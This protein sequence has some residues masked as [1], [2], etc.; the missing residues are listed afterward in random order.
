[1]KVQNSVWLPLLAVSGLL[2]G[3]GG[4]GGDERPIV[5]PPPPPSATDPQPEPDPE[6]I[7]D[8][9]KSHTFNAMVASGRHGF[10][11]GTFSLTEEG[12]ASSG[13][14]SITFH[15]KTNSYT[16]ITAGYEPTFTPGETLN[17]WQSDYADYDYYVDYRKSHQHGWDQLILFKTSMD[18]KKQTQHVA[19]GHWREMF[20]NPS[21]REEGTFHTFVYGYESPAS[22]VPRTGSGSFQIDVFGMAASPGNE[23]R[24]FDGIGRFD[25][26]FGAGSFSTHAKLIERQYPTGFLY[27][28][29]GYELSGSG[30]LSGSDGTFSGQI[31]YGGLAGTLP[32]T[33]N[34]RFYGPDAS[35]LGAILSADDGKG[36]T[37]TGGIIGWRSS[38]LPGVNETLT[39]I[40]TPELFSVH[41]IHTYAL[42][43][44]F[45]GIKPGGYSWSDGKFAV[46]PD[47]TV[48]I[49]M[50]GFG[51]R[52]ETLRPS[53]RVVSA[54]PNFTVYEK[55]VRY[56][57]EPLQDE[58][59]RLELYKPG[60]ANTELQL[61]YASFGHWQSART[62]SYLAN[63]NRLYFAY[64]FKT[65][66][67]ALS[68]RT[69]SA[70]YRGVVY[71]NG[72]NADAR[73][74]YDVTGT[75]EFSVNFSHQTYFGNLRV[76]GKTSDS[77]PSVDFGSYRFS[78]ALNTSNKIATPLARSD[79]SASSSSGFLEADFYGPKGE[80]IGG[81][82]RLGVA[83][84]E[85]GGGTQIIGA[86]VARQQ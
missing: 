28:G 84:G 21:N 69:G 57:V 32:G 34:G 86:T 63:G 19:L 35:E 33:L 11:A 39:N 45:P 62:D 16:L 18:G 50:F 72:Y 66:E 41:G 17:W 55:T 3:C 13:K 64:G 37:V 46:R 53:S 71:G 31:T 9:T 36:Y 85:P 2:A 24:T 22:A 49:M 5:T 60:Q 67:G 48:E 68:A 80:E 77:A 47:G 15:A 20:T 44:E 14:F 79:I 6:P 56:P 51:L 61:T 27:G 38:D 4:G 70:Y 40:R 75:S 1:M 59:I 82:F 29:P 43:T 26:D 23:P 81:A 12:Q 65:P 76:S 74:R 42:N 8:L 52:T 7:H 73:A 30:K 54:N 58:K 78:G 83:S 10:K 25:V